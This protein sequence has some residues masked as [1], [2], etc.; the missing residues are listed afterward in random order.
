MRRTCGAGWPI[1]TGDSERLR[2]KIRIAPKKGR[3][4][5]G[6]SKTVALPYGIVPRH[7]Q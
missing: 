1:A 3:D 4:L 5:G 6:F 2:C 7:V